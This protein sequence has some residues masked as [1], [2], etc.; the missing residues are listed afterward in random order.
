MEGQVQ[1]VL[2]LDLAPLRPELLVVGEGLELSQPLQVG[3]PPLVSQPGGDQAGQA[4]VGQPEEAARADAV[5]L[6]S[7][8]PRR[9]R[10]SPTVGRRSS[11]A[12]TCLATV[13]PGDRNSKGDVKTAKRGRHDPVVPRWRSEDGE[14]SR[15]HETDAHHWYDSH[16][17]CAAGHDCSAV[18]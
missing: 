9:V 18:E 5:G 12:V 3:Q 1:L 6:P 10:K 15:K 4:R 2:P 14:S 7:D 17:E 13:P 8:F 11:R 16:G